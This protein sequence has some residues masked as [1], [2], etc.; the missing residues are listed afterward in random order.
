MKTNKV[1]D[2]VA[3]PDDLAGVQPYRPKKLM[4]ILMS[5]DQM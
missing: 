2:G 4:I 1:A 5:M 3:V